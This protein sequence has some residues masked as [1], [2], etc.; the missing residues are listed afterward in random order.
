MNLKKINISLA[1]ASLLYGVLLLGSATTNYVPITANNDYGWKMFGVSGFS[2]DITTPAIKAEIGTNF[3]PL[4]DAKTEA[5]TSGWMAGDNN[6]AKLRLFKDATETSIELYADITDNSYDPT[7]S[8]RAIY[9]ASPGGIN[10]IARLEYISSLEGEQVDL[11][12]EGVEDSIVYT[13]QIDS[14]NTYNNPVIP[15]AKIESPAIY[16]EEDKTIKSIL[17]FDLSN[18]PIDPIAFNSN[19]HLDPAPNDTTARIYRYNSLDGVWELW[20]ND[21]AE[22]VNDFSTL[23]KG[24]AYW[25]KI[26]DGDKNNSNSTPPAGLI[27][28]N[29]GI[30]PTDYSNLTEGWNLV[31]FDPKNNS[32]RESITGLIV[33]DTHVGS[34]SISDITGLY[35]VDI[36]LS[37]DTSIDAKNINIAVNNAKKLGQIPENLKLTSFSNENGKLILLSN[38]KFIIEGDGFGSVTTLAGQDVWSVKSQKIDDFSNVTNLQNNSVSSIYGEYSMIIEPLVGPNTASNLDSYI[39][40]TN[41]KDDKYSAA[42]MINNDENQIIPFA[43][44]NEQTTL[45]TANDTIKKY[46][47]NN[48]TDLTNSLEI[49]INN[50]GI[51]DH[52]LISSTSNFDI[53][54]FT[55]TKVFNF[56]N[57][58]ANGILSYDIQGSDTIAPKVKP[59]DTNTTVVEIKDNIN[60]MIDETKIYATLNENNET[61]IIIS[62]S[63]SNLDLLN[64]EGKFFEK[65][66]ILED[67]SFI[68]LTKGAVKAIYNPK[69]LIDANMVK[70]NIVIPFNLD[71]SNDKFSTNDDFNITLAN[72]D[73]SFTKNLTGIGVIDATHSEDTLKMYDKIVDGF[74]Q[75]AT[76]NNIYAIASHDYNKGVDNKTSANIIITGFR[77]DATQTKIVSSGDVTNG[78]GSET[79]IDKLG[80]IT[81]P[82]PITEDLG[83]NSITVPDMP[84][85]GP[86]YVFKELGFDIKAL[87]TGITDMSTG[88]VHWSNL[89]L[90]APKKVWYDSNDYNLFDINGQTGYWAY[91]K[92]SEETEISATLNNISKSY[93][94]KFNANNKTTNVIDVT[95]IDLTLTGIKDTSVANVYTTISGNQYKLIP[96]YS[97]GNYYGY[98]GKFN[99]IEEGQGN[100]KDIELS[101]TDG[102]SSKLDK[103]SIGS[104]DTIQPN[105]PTINIGDG[106]NIEINSTSE[107]TRGYYV[108]NSY[109]P[110]YNTE[111]SPLKIQYTAGT[112]SYL[113]I[114]T[115][116]S[117]SPEFGKSVNT[118]QIF[119]VDGNGTLD[120]GLAS[121]TTSI[122]PH[123]ILKGSNVIT[124]TGLGDNTNKS[125]GYDS[126][127][128]IDESKSGDKGVTIE[129]KQV[130]VTVKLAFIPDTSAS[131]SSNGMAGIQDS[132]YIKLGGTADVNTVAK[133]LFD[134]TYNGKKFYIQIGN[135]TYMST[136]NNKNG[137]STAALYID[138]AQNLSN[139]ISTKI[140]GQSF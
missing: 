28:G 7:E 29:D 77:L 19:D 30:L 16:S 66:I 11:K 9:I 44:D 69:D 82:N 51:N 116:A 32:I 26:D 129:S 113:N 64:G 102:L 13:F 79:N 3:I 92:K 20:D 103:V 84:N 2:K 54:D 86:L 59:Q 40:G 42:I 95:D 34:C 62:A 98:I 39:N 80:T 78:V 87:V 56:N 14:N 110:E 96:G 8:T 53:K 55:F 106:S 4:I 76:D 107:D 49:D 137:T 75:L 48:K 118:L 104:I 36:N 111:A 94:H 35:K 120:T 114:C 45:T 115:E 85:E 93:S 61:L 128:V 133:V 6:L 60:E 109:V 23:D 90:T 100:K 99:S 1:T 46:I 136:F 41:N 81:L 91:L 101:A 88:N 43:E 119:S 27:L 68:N 25:I 70:N 138:Y 72:S 140:A 73:Q 139:E 12:R 130:G 71:D 112:K 108:Y 89:D 135:E 63:T 50:D 37:N 57:T 33:E 22:S 126:S 31:S 17:D 125:I 123:P 134:N 15:T 5:G 124:S 58:D 18:N 105:A 74:N 132:M 122:K 65:S 24:R 83:Y 21:N 131:A 97:S 117:L 47:S 38:T 67:D 10:P 121:N 52:L 127:C